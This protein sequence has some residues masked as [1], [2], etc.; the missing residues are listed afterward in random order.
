M[1]AES[2]T[3][4]GKGSASQ[5]GNS[6]ASSPGRVKPPPR[7]S[8]AN[9]ELQIGCCVRLEGLEGREELNGLVGRVEGWVKERKRW[10]VHCKGHEDSIYVRPEHLVVLDGTPPTSPR[11]DAQAAGHST[12]GGEG[13][14]SG[15]SGDVSDSAAPVALTPRSA[16]SSPRVAL[17]PNTATTPR[18]IEA[19]AEESTKSPPTP[20][21]TLEEETPPDPKVEDD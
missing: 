19:A 14:H 9:A 15:G 12:A 16:R 6:S 10:H 13:G 1:G 18:D 3:S 11:A 2:G 21:I 8:E 20:P 17:T 7:E 4:H 5:H